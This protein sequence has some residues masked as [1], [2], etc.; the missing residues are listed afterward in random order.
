MYSRG[1]RHNVVFYFVLFLCANIVSLIEPFLVAR[2][3]D[4]IQVQGVTPDNLRFILLLSS[5][6]I[7]LQLAFWLFHGPARVIETANAFQVRANYKLY[8]LNG[9]LDLP[10][11][12]HA[13]H[14]SGDTIDKIQK[15]TDA[16]YD[17]SS[18]TFEF[19]GSILRL[20]S[21]FLIL[22]YFDLRAGYVVTF[23]VVVTVYVIL[24]FDARL[25]DQYQ[26]D[27]PTSSVDLKNEHRIYQQ[28]FR[29]FKDKTVISSIHRLH[30][31]HL[32]DSIYFFRDGRIIAS[33]SF[34]ELLATSS[35][36]Q[37]LWRKYQKTHESS[38]S[39]KKRLLTETLK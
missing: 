28:I 14:H 19:L 9:T 3:L 21:A 10:A 20:L 6:F 33:G 22:A 32:F 1:N 24:K 8:L 5:I 35:L 36:F 34:E 39:G 23:M 38:S 37:S 15:G 12:W 11:A 31:L 17:Y 29:S 27:E 7:A 18:R 16:L 30:L 2:V 4:V 25:I 13:D 26:L